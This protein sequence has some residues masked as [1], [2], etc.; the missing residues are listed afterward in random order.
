MNIA[1]G[2]RAT[3]AGWAASTC[4]HAAVLVLLGLLTFRPQVDETI[5]L[6]LNAVGPQETVE[7]LQPAD[8]SIDEARFDILAQSASVAE[9]SPIVEAGLVEAEDLPDP[10]DSVEPAFSMVPSVGDLAAPAILEKDLDEPAGTLR[11][12]ARTA[13]H[14][15][16]GRRGAGNGMGLRGHGRERQAALESGGGNAESE[17]AVEAGLEWLARHQDPYGSWSFDHQPGAC[18]GRCSNPGSLADAR[19]GATGLALLPFLGDG[20]TH[21]DG[22][23][24]AQIKLGL[25]YLLSHM[26]D[27]GMCEPGGQMYS[28]GIAAIALGEAYGMTHDRDLYYPA[29]AAIAY[30]V[31]AQDPV[32][33]GWRYQPR[34]P[35]DTSVLGWQIM[36][37]KSGDMGY[38]LVPPDV[39]AG[40]MHFLDGVQTEGGAA[41]GYTEPGAGQATTA[42]GLL[43]RMHLGWDR[44]YTPLRRGVELLSTWGPAVGDGAVNM[45]YNYYGTQVLHHYGGKPWEDWNAVLRDY[46]IDAQCHAGHEAGSWP[47]SGGSDHGFASGGRLYATAMSLM[48]LEVYYRYLPLY[49]PR[50]FEKNLDVRRGKGRKG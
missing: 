37:L 50:S 32:G 33:G 20:Q 2:Y 11:A 4:L 12:G 19:L 36:A 28:H 22:K 31:A 6:V 34:Q 42:V 16:A 41:Y 23:Y 5:A 8:T 29:Q 1:K 14:G 27:G 18:Q 45:Y 30:I 46:L 26:Q 48:T 15:G 35:G 44:E 13:G 39:A 3:L 47:F 24:K 7:T 25:S 9:T 38:L 40:A 43:C 49:Q 17:S 21:L 10:A